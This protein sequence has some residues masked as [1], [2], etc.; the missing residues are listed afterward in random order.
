MQIGTWT[1]V[2]GKKK[3]DEVEPLVDSV[4]KKKRQLQNNNLPAQ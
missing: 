3:K 1:A 2:H 4:C